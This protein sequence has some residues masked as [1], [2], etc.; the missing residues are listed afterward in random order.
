MASARGFSKRCS[1]PV[2]EIRNPV[3]VGQIAL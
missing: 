3:L 1:S 2:R